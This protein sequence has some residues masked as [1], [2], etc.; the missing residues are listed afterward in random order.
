MTEGAGRFLL[1]LTL[2]VILFYGTLH[3]FIKNL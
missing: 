2:V 1:R 3:L